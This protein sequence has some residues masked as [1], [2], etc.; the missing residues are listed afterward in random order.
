MEY[1][2]ENYKLIDIRLGVIYYIVYYLHLQLEAL[3]QFKFSTYLIKQKYI[4]KNLQL[5]LFKL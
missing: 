5:T 2:Y 1:T 4:Y 3:P